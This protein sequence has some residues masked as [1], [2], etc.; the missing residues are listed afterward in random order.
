MAE[1]SKE[2]K[3]ALARGRR[4]SAAVKTYLGS[5]NVAKKRGRK[6]TPE[7]VDELR[8]Q[9]AAESDPLKRVE[10]VQKRLDLEKQLAEP[11][12]DHEALEA[13]FVEYAASYGEGK[14]ITY[15]AWREVG[16]PVSVLKA[17]GISRS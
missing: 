7:R 4:E 12:V 16:V 15:A 8:A 10:L 1:M 11:T 13:G 14:G 9:A 3:E 17:A 5:L 2:H 6:P